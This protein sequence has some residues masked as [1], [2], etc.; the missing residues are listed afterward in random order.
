MKNMNMKRYGLQVFADGDGT[1][2]EG[3][4]DGASEGNEDGDNAN[5]DKPMSFDDFLKQEGNQ[6]EFDR[7]VQKATQT[8]INNAK[9]K[10]QALTDDKLSEAQKLA[11]MSKEEKALYKAQQ[12]EKELADLKRKNALSE[13]TS[14]ARKMLAEDSIVVADELLN[15]IVYEDAEKTKESVEAF[16]R[17][18]KAAVQDGIKKQLTGRA[19]SKGSSNSITKEQIL[20]VKDPAERQRLIAE[21]MSLFRR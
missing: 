9:Q 7:R 11:K 2:A 19:P 6:A 18:Y 17:M 13:M 15:N 5:E 21:N 4:G 20:E 8:A 16:K 12:L 1:G 14:T 3:A 10:W